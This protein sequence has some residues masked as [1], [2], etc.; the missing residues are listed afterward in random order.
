MIKKTC[1]I[2]AESY[3]TIWSAYGCWNV[4]HISLGSL[5]PG[6]LSTLKRNVPA[7]CLHQG[8]IF[9]YM[10]RVFKTISHV[11]RILREESCLPIRSE[12][13]PLAIMQRQVTLIT[14]LDPSQ[15]AYS[16][17]QMACL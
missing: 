11:H 1:H 16:Q 7:T 14:I 6:N 2:K 5:K 8:I 4:T 13:L 12:K 9:L 3:D 17:A 15:N 10:G